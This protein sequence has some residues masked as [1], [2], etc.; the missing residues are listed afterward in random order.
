MAEG[1][2]LSR[3]AKSQSAS[4][5][6]RL[7]TMR[8]EISAPFLERLSGKRQCFRG[9]R[10]QKLQTHRRRGPHGHPTL[11]LFCYLCRDA[12]YGASRF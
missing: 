2:R 7:P 3:P 12:P 1:P 11:P 9:E 4:G 8:S 6:R 5:L 10:S